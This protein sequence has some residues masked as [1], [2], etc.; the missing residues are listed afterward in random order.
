MHELY[1]PKLQ[2]REAQTY[3][4]STAQ[5]Y[6]I[7]GRDRSCS[8][9][10]ELCVRRN[11][12]ADIYDGG[13]RNTLWAGNSVYY[14]SAVF[15]VRHYGSDT[16]CAAGNG[17]FGSAYGPVG[18]RNSGNKDCLDLRV[19]SESQVA[20]FSVHFLSGFLD[21]YDPH[22]GGMFLFRAEE[23]YT[24]YTAGNIKF[25]PQRTQDRQCFIDLSPFLCYDNTVIITAQKGVFSWKIH[26]KIERKTRPENGRI[27]SVS[28]FWPMYGQ[29]E[30]SNKQKP[31]KG[32]S[33]YV[34]YINRF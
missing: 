13:G 25:A 6:D 30:G 11:D 32:G 8:G 22:A 2:C 12:P 19:V 3:G 29:T 33:E 7:I 4:Q 14:D 5:L 21:H 20:L 17:T 15:P 16:G 28:V 23:M 34:G 18:N 24:S 9:S 27:T 10:W 31:W 1:K 26:P